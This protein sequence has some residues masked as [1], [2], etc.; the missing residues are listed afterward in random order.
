MNFVDAHH[1][2]LVWN[3]LSDPCRMLHGTKEELE[4]VFGVSDPQF[5]G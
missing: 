3:C 5:Q 1:H 2:N 4:A